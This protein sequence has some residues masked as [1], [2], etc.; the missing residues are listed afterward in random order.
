[1]SDLPLAD[2]DI[3]ALKPGRELDALISYEIFNECPHDG[4]APTFRSCTDTFDCSC[5][6]CTDYICSGCDKALC[7]YRG[8]YDDGTVKY[9]DENDWSCPDYSTDLNAAMR[10]VNKILESVEG[11]FDLLSDGKQGYLATF[12]TTIGAASSKSQTP[13]EAV[14]KAALKFVRGQFNGGDNDRKQF[15]EAKQ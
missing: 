1:M 15:G 14:C 4:Q 8:D 7:D 9:I 6:T 3:D 5:L 12:C 13:A 10:V 2:T 11:Y